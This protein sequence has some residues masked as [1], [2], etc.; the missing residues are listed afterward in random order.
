M[1]KIPTLFLQA[2]VVFIG[3]AAIAALVLLPLT[4]GRTTHLDLFSIYTDPFI[5]YAYVTS[6]AFFVALYNAFKLL[7]YIRQNK[8][9]STNSL[10]TLK[11]IRYC[12]I[13]FSILII[14]AGVYIKLWHNKDDDPAGFLSIC[15]V[16]ILAVVV[17]IA[18]VVVFERVL[19]K[20]IEIKS[21]NDLT[22]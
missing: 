2:V 9:F 4:E 5:L 16:A 12:A 14:A 11:N 7:G 13:L 6:I 18:A 10:K 8:I 21:E 15:F 3:I 20:A 22:I 17:V 19:K 1:K